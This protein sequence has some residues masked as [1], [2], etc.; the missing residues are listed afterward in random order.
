MNIAN[1]I[2]FLRIVGTLILI[3]T[4]PFSKRFFV[5]YTFTGIT[6]VLD[7]FFARK[8]KCASEF[9]AKLDSVADILF[10]SVMVLKILPELYVMMPD[11]IWY[12][13]AAILLI[14]VISYSVTAI[15]T[16]RFMSNHTHL[17]KLTGLCV[18]SIPYFVNFS[19]LDVGF[20]LIA[21]IVAALAAIQELA[22]SIKLRQFKE[23]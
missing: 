6:D 11:W 8:F 17:N 23:G 18:F 9:G 12:I 13:V 14:R 15:K 16:H 7:G 19:D 20:C 5:I 3:L 21:C 22:Y 10:Y 2:T 1:F 4:V